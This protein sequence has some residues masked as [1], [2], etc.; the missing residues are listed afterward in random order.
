MRVIDDGLAVKLA[1]QKTG[2]LEMH[3]V[4]QDVLPVL[5]VL[6]IVFAIPTLSGLGEHQSHSNHVK[7]MSIR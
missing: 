5:V 7:A 6:V 1:P 3:G 4:L 2:N